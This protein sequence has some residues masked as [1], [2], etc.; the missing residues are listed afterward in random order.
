MSDSP[1]RAKIGR[2]LHPLVF[3]PDGVPPVR[4]ELRHISASDKASAVNAWSLENADE[5]RVKTVCDALHHAGADD[6]DGV[7]GVQRYAAVATNAEGGACG[8]LILRYR[9]EIE[10]E[11]ESEFGDSEPANGKGLV[12]Q[13]MRHSEAFAKSVA[14]SG[15]A[16]DQMVRHSARQAQMIEMMMDK[17]LEHI[18]L[19]EELSN[20][21]AAR[22]V[23]A[24]EAEVKA[25]ATEEIAKTAAALL[26]AMIHKFTGVTPQNYQSPEVVALRKLA[27][28]LTEREIDGLQSTLSPEHAATVMEILKGAAESEAQAEETRLTKRNGATS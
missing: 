25:L 27:S 20:D 2:W 7:G 5:T 6:A 8:R 23:M 21:K 16:L 17:H 22:D 19:T 12:A 15:A 24:R 13:A 28:A 1:N 11:G 9:A 4:V 18:R 10:H 3:A 14:M 26:P